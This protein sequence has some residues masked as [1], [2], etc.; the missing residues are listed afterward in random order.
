M[1]LAYDKMN[2]LS[3]DLVLRL[4]PIIMELERQENILIIGHQAV[5]RAICKKLYSRSTSITRSIDAY[6]FNLPQSQ[7]PYIHIPLHTVI[8][9]TPKAYGCDELTESVGIEAVD[10]HRPR[11]QHG[12]RGS[13]GDKA[14][15]DILQKH[16]T[17]RNVQ[18]EC[19]LE[20]S[21]GN[22]EEGGI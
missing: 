22:D 18:N 10:T 1:I 8:Q 21:K 6:F 2:P 19:I 14:I 16:E 11:P 17:R 7:M 9:L 15:M 20:M 12:Q 3:Q 4:E 5:L 13:Y